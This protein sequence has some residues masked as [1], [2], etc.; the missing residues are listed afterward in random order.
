MFGKTKIFS[1]I[2]LPLFI[3]FNTFVGKAL[4]QIQQRLAT[5]KII[6][7]ILILNDQL[8]RNKYQEMNI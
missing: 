2:R 7:F 5:I 4:L 8:E 1:Q 6:S 3:P